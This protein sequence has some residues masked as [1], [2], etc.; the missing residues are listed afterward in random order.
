MDFHD[1]LSADL[2]APRDDEPAS[3]RDDIVDELAGHLACMYRREL[4]RGA[5]TSTAKLRAREA[6]GDPADLAR[7]LW[8][9]AMKGKIMSQ[10]ILVSCCIFLT[11]ISLTLAGFLWMQVI[12]SRRMAIA[13]EA[14]ARDQSRLAQA[15]Q[16]E[17]IRQLAAVSKA[18]ENPRAPDWIPVSFKLTQE[19]LDGPPGVG[20]QAALG[21]G[22]GGSSK[23]E[24]IQRDSDAAGIVDFGVV[25]PGDWEFRTSRKLEDKS[26][27]SWQTSGKLNVGLRKTIEK[28]IICPRISS[29]QPSLTV[30]IDWPADLA[31]KDLAALAAFHH[32]GFVYQPPLQWNL[33]TS[34]FGGWWSNR[35][36]FVREPGNRTADIAMNGFYFWRLAT[37]SESGMAQEKGSAGNLFRQNQVYLDLP[38]FDPAHALKAMPWHEGAYEMVQIAVAKPTRNLTP[39]FQGERC[40]LLAVAGRGF[41]NETAFAVQEPPTDST[42]PNAGQIGYGQKSFIGVSTTENYWKETE[43]G[44]VVKSGH[45]NDWI[46]HL[47][48]ELTKAVREK[49]KSDAEAKRQ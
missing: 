3:L 21:R 31:G 29:K 41:L 2:P 34:P 23:P 16:E 47:P 49:M 27:G 33:S 13:T 4:L 7:R 28:A 5:D 45:P 43:S 44:L 36:C 10:R 9:D 6:F 37:E 30:H 24:A 22:T 25:Q 8:F 11:M 32:K 26:S 35:T 38:G 46:I 14:R 48:D 18:V 17:M 19:T 39:S 40:E 42:I 12:D 15:A 1:G 20:F